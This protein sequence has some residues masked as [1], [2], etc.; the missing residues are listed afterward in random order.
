LA[1][2]PTT[3]I[4]SQ[5]DSYQKLGFF[6]LG[7]FS[8]GGIFATV[9]DA[10]FLTLIMIFWSIG[11]WVW[12]LISMRWKNSLTIF[13]D[14]LQYSQQL[15]RTRH[16]TVFLSEIESFQFAEKTSIKK[17]S[18]GGWVGP[19]TSKK[20]VIFIKSKSNPEGMTFL[21]FSGVQMHKFEEVKAHLELV[22][23]IL[24]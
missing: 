14:R 2:S 13:E 4:W 7:I 20:F 18:I 8:F 9:G 15:L 3:I 23:K 1:D 21:T 19:V 10:Y 17:R 16:I 6:I 5:F 12:W 11:L 24:R 22:Q